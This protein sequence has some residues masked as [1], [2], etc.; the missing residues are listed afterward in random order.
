LTPV[1][2]SNALASPNAHAVLTTNDMISKIRATT[3]R[4]SQQDSG[5]GGGGGLFGWCAGVVVAG[6]VLHVRVIV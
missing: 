1:N 4:S 2:L 3:Y 5:G 6:V